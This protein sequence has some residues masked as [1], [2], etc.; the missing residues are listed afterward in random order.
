VE[1]KVKK[2]QNV[3]LRAA[4]SDNFWPCAAFELSGSIP[5]SH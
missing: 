3:G 4:S 1:I 2:M 5:T